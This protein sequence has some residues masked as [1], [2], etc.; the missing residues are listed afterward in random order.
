[1]AIYIF[2]LVVGYAPGGL[3][4]AQGYRATALKDFFNPAQFVFT[5]IPRRKDIDLYRNLG[6]DVTQMLSM[7]QYLTDNRTL[8]LSG[9]TEE[10]LE[11]LKNTLSCTRVEYR[12]TAV[13]LIKD[14]FVVAE[15]LLDEN[16]KGSFWGVHYYNKTRLIRTEFYTDGIVYADYYVTANSDRGLYAKTVRRT[17]YNRDGSVAYD[18]IWKGREVQYLFPDG[19]IC[20]KSQFIA[21]FVKK[22]NLS[23]QDIVFLDRG[24]QSDF[25]Q[26]LF[27]Y[28]KKARLMTFFHSGHY[29]EKGEDPHLG[30]LYFNWAYLYWLKYTQKIDTMVV[31]TQEQKEE[32]IKKL[33]EYRRCVP[34]VEVIPVAGIDRLRYPE[35]ERKKYSL[36]TVSRINRRKRIDWIIKSVIKAHQKNPNIFIDIY[37]EDEYGHLRD[38][39]EIVAAEQAQSYVRFMG[40][41][42]VAEVYKNY[43]VYLSASLWETLG[44]SV[45]EAAAS[46]N[47]LI[48]LNVKYGNRL[49]IRPEENGYLIDFDRS[50]V[51]GDD[52]RLIDDMAERIVEIFEDRERLEQFHRVSYEVAGG[53]S[54]EIIGEKWRRLLS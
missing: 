21:E 27:Q 2:D 49:F 37:G 53:F 39:E 12:D 51:D 16:D 14:H 52:S 6:M 42:D 38:L 48:G 45:M 47:A 41:R 34:N 17:F 29:Y 30:H 18:M 32:L 11:E 8:E 54:T 5:E 19:R 35:T 15:I 33:Q 10:K 4:R 23:E 24:S 9:K 40:Y 46:G 31:S 50:Y 7:H 26:P 43:E 13:R 28:G 36:I 44:L 20:T 1:M 22:L 3:E 25:V